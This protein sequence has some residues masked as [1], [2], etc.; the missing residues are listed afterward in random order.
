MITKKINIG[1]SCYILKF[2]EFDEDVDIDSLLKID[3]SNLLGEM[4]TFPTVVAKFGNMLAEAES[5]VNEKKLDLDITE[6]KL[7]EKYRL[8]LMEA[9]GGKS[10]TVDQLTTAVI[11][12][13]VFFAKKKSYISAQKT[14]DYMLT[15]Y[16]AAKDKSEKINKVFFQ[17]HP[18]DIPEQVI[19]GRMNSTMIKKAKQRRLID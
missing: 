5:Q 4:I 17:A 2:D 14:R 8:Q 1:D 3:Y 16:L 6:A 18:G 7:K 11:Q 12:D 15:T 10:P 19:E 13:K 9:N